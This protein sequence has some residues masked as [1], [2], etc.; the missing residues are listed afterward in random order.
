M[1][2]IFLVCVMIALAT[3]ASAQTGSISGRITDKTGESVIGAVVMVLDS[4]AASLPVS[5]LRGNFI[6]RQETKSDGR[7]AFAGLP[8]THYVLRVRMI[9]YCE[10]SISVIV[11]ADAEARVD[12]EMIEGGIHVNENVASYPQKHDVYHEPSGIAP[13]KSLILGTIRDEKTRQPIAFA[14]ITA[15]YQYRIYHGKDCFDVV[16]GCC[17]SEYADSLGRF[18]LSDLFPGLYR[19]GYSASDSTYARGYCEIMT[20]PD[21]VHHAD[22]ML[23]KGVFAK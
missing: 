23:A 20:L 17:L 13:G 18:G 14:Y 21:S 15:N 6:V 10:Q 11:N 8:P 5:D 2:R 1:S 7:Y 4:A 9:G 3:A 22:L 16:E 19:L 12:V